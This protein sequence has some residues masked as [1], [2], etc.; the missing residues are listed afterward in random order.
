[1][2]G[3]FAAAPE[4]S[5]RTA[6]VTG[7][8]RSMGALFTRALAERGVNV[9][10]GDLDID[11]MTQTAAEINDEGGTRESTVVPAQID[12]TD[13]AGHERLAQIAQEWFG[14]VDYWVNNAGIFQQAAAADI[15]PEQ[16]RAV[17]AVNVEGVLYGSQAAARSMAGRGGAIVNLASISAFRVVPERAA[18]SMSK[19]S[20]DVMTRF[21]ALEFGDAGIRVNAVAPG[22]IATEMTQWLVSDPAA[23]ARE[24]SGIPLGRIGVPEDILDPVLFLLSD[25]ARYVTGTTLIVD[26][27]FRIR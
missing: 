18:Y 24:A 19:S 11:R 10:G 22:L 14:G 3:S 23:A 1:M 20:V 15:V 16:I 27:G 4:F 8:A 9:V 13:P 26:G 25:S 5:G 6:V 17:F 12:V 2:I 21:L 7:A